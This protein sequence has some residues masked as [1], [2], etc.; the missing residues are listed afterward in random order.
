MGRMFLLLA[1]IVVGG[2]AFAVDP[3]GP[4]CG[5]AGASSAYF[6]IAP[7]QVGEASL[8]FQRLHDNYFKDKQPFMPVVGWRN[9]VERYYD[10][11]NLRLLKTN[12]ELILTEQ[13]NLP[14][15]RSRREL[16]TYRD[17]STDPPTKFEFEARRYNKKLTPL[18][19]HP[20]FG[21]VQRKA[22][23]DLITKLALADDAQAIQIVAS[24]EVSHDEIV[25][26]IQ[27]FGVPTASI[28]IDKFHIASFGV[29]NTHTLVKFELL[30]QARSHLSDL[31]TSELTGMYC[32]A[33]NE[34]RTQFPGLTAVPEF[35]YRSY[36]R[37]AL[38]TLP[39]RDLFRRYPLLYGIGQVV[40]L[41]VIGFMILYL[42]FGRYRPLARYRSL[43]T[44]SG[45]ALHEK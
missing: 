39:A 20:L 33:I 37:L 26:L 5:E 44:N 30:P 17:H 12:Q 27:H 43:S 25:Y 36:H 15:Y 22:R 4:V 13:V 34:F 29:P 3:A 16:V 10:D 45:G 42:L 9:V 11:R 32:T 8:F 38:E 21:K 40:V 31:E 2:R 14:R 1:L 24:V 18:D 35:G 28:S 41:T 23:P 19:K 6:L 7:E